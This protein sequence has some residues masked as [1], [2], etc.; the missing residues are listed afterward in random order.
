MALVISFWLGF[1]VYCNLIIW[2]YN[3]YFGLCFVEDL[4]VLLIS[5]FWGFSHAEVQCLR[6]MI[7]AIVSWLVVVELL[8]ELASDSWVC[9]YPKPL[10][11][12]LAMIEE[13]SW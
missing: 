5:L 6:L 13:R 9:T 8:S 1:W 11:D 3:R 7:Y 12:F 4:W 10:C 2:D